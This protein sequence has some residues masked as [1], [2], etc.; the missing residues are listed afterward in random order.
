MRLGAAL[1]RDGPMEM[2][3]AGGADGVHNKEE[4]KMNIAV[5]CGSKP[6]REEKYREAA[7]KIGT[8]IGSHGH[9]LIYGAGALGTM[10][11]VADSVQRSAGDRNNSI[12][13]VIPQFM[14]DRGWQKRDLTQIIVTDSM[15]SRKAKMLELADIY[16]A[17]PGGPG[18]LEEITEA[19]SLATLDQ[20]AKKCILCSLDGYYRPLQNMYQT[21][22]KEGFM[23]PEMLEH[24]YI[25][26]SVED[27]LEQMEEVALRG[28]S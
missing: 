8:Y 19:F 17:M 13:G 14:V 2:P 10:G 15:S 23:L 22:V 1:Y 4:E 9:T 5:Y 12:I 24:L 25:A 7:E 20:H 3:C 28:R 26:E 11:S 18:T 6:G 27:V 16:I 21:M